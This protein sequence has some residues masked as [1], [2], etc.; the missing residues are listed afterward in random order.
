MSKE[1][2]WRVLQYMSLSAGSQSTKATGPHEQPPGAVL[3]PICT[4]REYKR[5]P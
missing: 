4:N 5:D 3:L 2:T 1:K